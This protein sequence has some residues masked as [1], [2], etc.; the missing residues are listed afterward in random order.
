MGVHVD[1]QLLFAVD[2]N[3]SGCMGFECWRVFMK[4]WF[5]GVI[6]ELTADE[7]NARIIGHSPPF[8]N[9]F[10]KTTRV[11]AMAARAVSARLAWLRQMFETTSIVRQ[12]HLVFGG[13]KALR[14]N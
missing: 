7:V 11:R 10:Y 3:R 1:H 6:S 8:R 9:Y 2:D 5:V 12:R 13:F 4:A 14:S